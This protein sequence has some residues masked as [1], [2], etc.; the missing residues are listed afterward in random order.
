MWEEEHVF[1]A[2]RPSE[3]RGSV[4][5]FSRGFAGAAVMTYYCSSGLLQV[6]GVYWFKQPVLM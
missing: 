4:G 2:G 6:V 5:R 3:E 1:I